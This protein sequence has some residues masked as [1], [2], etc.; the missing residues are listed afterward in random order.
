MDDA[1][2]QRIEARIEQLKQERDQYVAQANQQLAAYNGA[3]GELE[4]LLKP[5]TP[6]ATP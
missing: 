4:T 1:T 5:E 3:I 6:Q 2:Q